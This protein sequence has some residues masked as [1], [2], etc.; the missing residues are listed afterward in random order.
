MNKKGQALVEFVLILPIFVFMILA[1]IDIGKIYYTK[2]RLEN[3][4][5]DVIVMKENNKSLKEIKKNVH[6]DLKDTKIVINDKDEYLEFKL[7]KQIEI[8]TPGL[9]L[10]FKNP[11]NVEVKRVIYNE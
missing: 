1:T 5:N 4:L 6:N 10:I 2:N 9:N 7:S 8:V 3:K 11:Y